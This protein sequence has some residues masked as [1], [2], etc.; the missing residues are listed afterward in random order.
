MD[1][2]TF[3]RLLRD[4][5]GATAVEYA[6]IAVLIGIACITAFVNL[7][8]TVSTHYSEVDSSVGGAIN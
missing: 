5:R 1:R 6:L 2:T 8:D 7:G 4:Q 3:R